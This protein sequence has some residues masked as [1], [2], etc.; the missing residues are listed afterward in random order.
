MFCLRLASH[1][2]IPLKKFPVPPGSV[3]EGLGT[4]TG[5]GECS[6][7]SLVPYMLHNGEPRGEPNSSVTWLA[8]PRSSNIAIVGHIEPDRRPHLSPPLLKP[9]EPHANA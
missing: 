1:Y 6:W 8:E 3:S 5:E 4:L 2:S 9:T 7:A